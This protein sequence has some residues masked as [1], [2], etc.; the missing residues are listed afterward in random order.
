MSILCIYAI[1]NDGG[2]SLNMKLNL[3]Q[4]SLAVKS[5][6]SNV[7][8]KIRTELAEIFKDKPNLIEVSSHFF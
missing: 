4:F 2:N 8:L 7:L 5:S 3:S 1:Q 6:Y